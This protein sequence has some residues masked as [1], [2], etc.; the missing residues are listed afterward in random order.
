MTFSE[1]KA[2]TTPLFSSLKIVKVRDVIQMQ[3]LKL[4]F[5]YKQNT[6]PYDLMSLFEVDTNIHSYSTSS[7]SKDLLHIPE[8]HTLTYG[9]KSIRYHCPYT[10]NHTFKNVVPINNNN[11]VVRVDG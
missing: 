1:Y 8:I 3:H 11:G 2:H 7:A 5:E 4:V 6:L 10:W 9:N